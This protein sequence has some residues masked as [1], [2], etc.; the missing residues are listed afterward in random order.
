MSHPPA[1]PPGAHP[2]V[3]MSTDEPPKWTIR[4]AHDGEDETTD[5]PRVMGTPTFT[6]LVVADQYRAWVAGEVAT[7]SYPAGVA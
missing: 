7:F 2:F 1:I 6:Q 3:A 5:R 4:Y